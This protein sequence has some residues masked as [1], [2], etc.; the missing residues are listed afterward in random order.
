MRKK[1]V[2]DGRMLR[3]VEA[4]DS[5]LP[6]KPSTLPTR[7]LEGIQINTFAVLEPDLPA[8]SPLRGACVCGRSAYYY[9]FKVGSSR[10]FPSVEGLNPVKRGGGWIS[11]FF[12]PA[13]IL[14]SYMVHKQ[15]PISELE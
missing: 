9:I 11:S 15:C 7:G 14:G 2:N 3:A 12:S 5:D 10:A 6:A 4:E 8:P 13:V 1:A